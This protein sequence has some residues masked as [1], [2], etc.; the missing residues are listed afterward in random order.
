MGGKSGYEYEIVTALLRE[1][2]SQ[3][4]YRWELCRRD[5]THQRHHPNKDWERL[6]SCW[7]M[8]ESL[9]RCLRT[10]GITL[11]ADFAATHKY[12]LEV[13]EAAKGGRLV[14]ASSVDG[15]VQ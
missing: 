6:K 7:M 15:L 13:L 4:E 5:G 8:M 1:D 9:R 10:A 12:H 2:G 11:M 3:K 14:W